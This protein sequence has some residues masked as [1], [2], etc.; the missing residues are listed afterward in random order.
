MTRGFEPLCRRL[1]AVALTVVLALF[2]IGTLTTVSMEPL[3]PP[4]L[5]PIVTLACSTIGMPVIVPVPT[6]FSWPELAMEPVTLMPLT[7][8]GGMDTSFAED[9]HEK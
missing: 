6:R 9:G 5:T 2:I 3:K 1:H 7:D 4:L 8:S